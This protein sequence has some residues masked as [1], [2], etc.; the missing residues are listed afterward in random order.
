PWPPP[1]PKPCSAPGSSAARRA[2][3]AR[4]EGPSARPWVR[5]TRAHRETHHSAPSLCPTVPRARDGWDKPARFFAARVFGAFRRNGPS[6]AVA[7]VPFV[8]RVPRSR[9]SPAPRSGLA[10]VLLFPVLVCCTYALEKALLC[11][12]PSRLG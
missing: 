1:M 7:F 10:F 12:P 2:S 4:C 3:T 6:D 11:E 5:P 8:P 9:A